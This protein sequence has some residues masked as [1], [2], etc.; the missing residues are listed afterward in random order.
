MTTK[1]EYEYKPVA[2]TEES[3]AKYDVENDQV[4]LQSPAMSAESAEP[5]DR[6][7]LYIA[8]CVG[9]IAAFVCG[10]SF[11]WTSPE[12]PKLK[13][14]H[15]EGNPLPVPIT[16]DEE[17]WIGS[18]LPVGATMG[19]FVAGFLADKIGRKNTL[20][21][22]IIP[23]IIA[24][25]LASF[26]TS[27]SMFF[28]VRFLCGLAVGVIFTV[29][30]MYIGEIAE[31]EVRDSLGSFMQLFIEIFTDAGSTI[32]ADISTIIIGVVQVF[33]SG[34]TPIL[35]EKKGKRFLL[36]L[37]AVGM[38]VSQGALAVFFQIKNGGGDVSSIALLPVISLV[39]YIV[40][41]CLGFG[42]LPWAV[43]GE[44]FPGN[45]VS[46]VVGTSL[47]WS[48]PI[49][50]KLNATDPD[51]IP[52]GRQ[53]TSEE[54]SWIGS[55]LA[56]GA[57][58][59][60][61]LY[62]YIVDKFG[63][64]LTITSIGV[65]FAIS[66]LIL[67][68]AQIVELYYV[69]RFLIGVAVGGVFTVVPMYIGEIAEDTNRGA[70][71]SV[72][73]CLLT[74]GLLFS[75]GIGPYISIMIFNIILAII[76]GIFMVAFFFLAP[77]SPHHHIAKGNHEAAVKSLE[78]LRGA[79]N[80]NNH[81]ELE[82][83]KKNIEKSRQGSITDL[84]KSKGLIKA[85]IISLVLVALQQLSGIN[86]VLFYAQNIFEAS[87]SGLESAQASIII[88]AVQFGTSFVTPLFV[89]RLGRKMLLYFSAIGMVISEIPLGLYFYLK[90]DGQ[91]VDSISW[92]PIVSLVVYIITYNCG[93]GPLPWAIM[94]EL[95]PSNVK[96]AA[97]SFTAAVC[98]FFGF[99][100]TKFFSSISEEIGMGPSRYQ[101]VSKRYITSLVIAHDS[102][103]RE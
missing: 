78:K 41:Y 75:Y 4:K 5:T 31:D 27:P 86:V 37:S 25:L 8:A 49:L 101:R 88:G 96:S 94:G 2:G 59:G 63:R 16:K 99:I 32:P 11:G 54:N 55:L 95:F 21:L 13:V 43:M 65:P 42:P 74:A 38:A 82:D 71:G 28:T 45:I 6:K 91:D 72:M 23:F 51:D 40:T 83:I 34:A 92:L 85:L 48:S 89:D 57:V 52:F 46:F 98:W 24:F 87:G 79:S 33:A 3:A 73:N 103:I 26:A 9:N 29:L 58:F 14:S 70:L 15:K 62:A 1:E 64:K 7:F 100:I 60:P 22:G 36:I 35:V 47:T 17:S 50:P 10:T 39:I 97:S 81:S 84:F 80:K 12:G 93:F 90:D 19:P 76:P 67:A 68:F 69:A 18:L 66:Y 77:E 102:N 20:L 44:L 61:F 30:P 56:L 53:I